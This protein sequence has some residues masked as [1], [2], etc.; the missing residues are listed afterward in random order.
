M[1]EKREVR[2]KEVIE[3]LNAGMQ[4]A[5]LCK[6]YRLSERGLVKVLKKLVSAKLVSKDDI[7]PRIHDIQKPSEAQD[8]RKAPR[9]YP[10]FGILIHE[11][12]DLAVDYYIQ[13]VSEKGFRIAG[14]PAKV[15]EVRTFLIQADE[16][17]DVFPFSFEARCRWVKADSNMDEY[18]AGFEI[19]KIS[20][21]G[22]NELKQII[23]HM[24]IGK[25]VTADSPED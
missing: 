23:R 15:G 1:K 18:T 17:V 16:F 8:I 5:E 9:C 25:S 6:K 20:E 14:M 13:D 7:A 19:S 12:D 4:N 22:A 10:V 3:D 2:A 24:T 11:L 21:Q